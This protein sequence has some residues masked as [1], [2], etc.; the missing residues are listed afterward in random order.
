MNQIEVP[1]ELQKTG[2]SEW[3]TG[4]NDPTRVKVRRYLNGI[5]TSSS[6]ALLTQ[7]MIRSSEDHNYKLSASVG[8]Y[9]LSMDMSPIDR[10]D[11]TE[12]YID[13]LFGSGRY[14]DAKER[15][16]TNLDLF[17][18]V[19]EEILSRNGGE[20]P[21]KIMCRNRLIDIMVGIDYAYDDA[22]SILDDFVDIGILDPDE[23][24]Y[25]K[26]S[27]KIHRMQKSF[28]NV[29]IYRPKQ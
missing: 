12:A 23:V 20:L 16:C 21:K 4:L 6:S 2:L 25:R 15:C 11:V 26:Q 18:E 22:I 5:D 28:D 13:G 29:F 27:L 8:E 1:M 9:A 3:Y 10:F 17:P 7:L 19:K 14:E 24:S